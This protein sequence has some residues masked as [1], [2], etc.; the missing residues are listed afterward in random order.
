[1]SHI[2]THSCALLGDFLAMNMVTLAVNT[3]HVVYKIGL[4]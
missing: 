1:M 2:C 3:L 4:V